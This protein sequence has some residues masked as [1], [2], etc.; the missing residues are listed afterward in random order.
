METSVMYNSGAET[1]YIMMY[2]YS[3]PANRFI[4]TIFLDS[5][6]MY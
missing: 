2:L 3:F 5:I 4:N 1:E 6:F